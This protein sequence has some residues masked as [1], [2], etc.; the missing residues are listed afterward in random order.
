MLTFR[1]VKWVWF[2]G[3]QLSRYLIS[4]EILMRLIFSEKVKSR[5]NKN[6]QN[7]NLSNDIFELFF[8]LHLIQ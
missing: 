1:H 8:N 7:N 6:K 5:E 4:R 3:I 2:W